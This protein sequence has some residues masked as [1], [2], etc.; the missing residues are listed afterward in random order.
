MSLTATTE[1]TTYG[2]AGSGGIPTRD[3]V[4][5]TYPMAA[6]ASVSS[7]DWVKL[8]STTAGTIVKCSAT[9]DS[10][11]GIAFANVDNT[12]GDDG[13]TAG[14][15]G[16]KFCPVLRR[17]FAYVDGVVAASGNSGPII[18]FDDGL[19]LAGTVSTEGQVLSATS[20][21]NG[22]VIVARSFDRVAAVTTS[23]LF[24]I[25]V[26]IDRLT[27]SVVVV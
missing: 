22:D 1:P 7:G 9:S 11:I 15:A 14:A 23:A 3:N 24:K 19:Y 12:Y 10:P 13:V 16:G 25:R 21:A 6:S 5:L 17:G 18:N 27:K 2:M 8:T 4:V 20:T 26:Y